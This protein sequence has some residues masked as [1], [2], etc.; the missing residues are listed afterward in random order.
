MPTSAEANAS[1]DMKGAASLMMRMKKTVAGSAAVAVASALAAS[2]VC[3]ASAANAQADQPPAGGA[4][5]APAG[6]SEGVV[7]IVNDNIISSYDLSQ[8]VALLIATTGVRPTPQNLPQLQQEA[9][10]GLIDERLEVDE[11]RREEKEQKFSIMADDDEV[12]DY[13]GRIAQGS[14]MTTE[15]LFA[16]LG[17]VGV[18]P[19]TLKDQIRAQRSWAHWIQGRYGG[20]RL[21]IGQDQ[22]NLAIQA[23]EAE[24][25]K[26]QYNLGEIF[27]DA[28]RA[29]GIDQATN[30]AQQLITQMQQG[31]PFAAVARQ[32]S[33]TSTAANG[34]DAGWLTESAMP[35]EVRAAVLQMRAGQLSAP[36]VTRDGVY[37][38]LL[39]D[40]R[41]GS[42][43]MIVELKQAAISL[44][45]SATDAAVSAA[46]TKLMALKAKITSCADVEPQAAKFD[47]VVAGDLGQTDLK[48]LAPSFQQAIAGL[49]VGQVSD[50]IRT[51]A[52]LHLI[53]LCDRHQ[54]G[55]NI[56]SRDEI[57]ARLEDQQL[58]LISRRYLRDLRSSA[59]IETR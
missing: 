15:Q 10:R 35:P 8:R 29:G 53:A 36:I 5:A 49:K 19:E 12:N 7:A 6:L 17:S 25:A 9:L 18:A 2:M 59:T 11:I 54:S 43:S 31:A 48:D 45:A 13:I 16:A 21:K 4:A 51:S 46:Q 41:A 38:I 26:P 50:P 14:R 56:P 34:G 42:D 3:A 37:I 30:G 27:I 22:I 40:K 47:G 20:S 39:K 1:R 24:A 23:I 28:S 44:D 58:D 33:S 32:F 52:G 55:V 57:E